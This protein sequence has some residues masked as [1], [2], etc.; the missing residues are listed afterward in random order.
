MLFV[1]NTRS[2]AVGLAVYLAMAVL[3]AYGATPTEAVLKYGGYYAGMRVGEAELKLQLTPESYDITGHAWTRGLMHLATGW[4]SDFA[5]SGRVVDGK[6]DPALYRYH[7]SRRDGRIR[8]TIMIG[9]QWER[10][11]EDGF[12]E[13]GSV[14]QGPDILSALFYPGSC[15]AI[16]S[17]H[18][19]RTGYRLELIEHELPA[20]DTGVDYIERCKFDV[21]DD[22][23]DTYQIELRMT[24]FH[25][26]RVPLDIDLGG[27]ISGHVRLLEAPE[28]LLSQKAG[29]ERAP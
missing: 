13:S 5:A 12:D 2:R 21:E 3:P 28:T 14:P 24:E 17:L 8:T 25:G 18:T 7:D 20:P 6:P 1:T 27:V 16:E 9:K 4:Q 10:Y 19:A 23:G 15:E 26:H 29:S 11:D 22:D